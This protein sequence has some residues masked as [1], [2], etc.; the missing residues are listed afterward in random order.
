MFGLLKKI[1]GTAQSR[2]LKRY[3]KL[4]KEVNRQDLFLMNLSDEA[5]RLKT[6]EFKNR[7]SQGE[8]LEK[9]LPE[10]YAVVKNVCRRLTGK[11]IHVSGYDQRWDM[12][13]YDT[14]VLAAIAMHYGNIAEMQTGEGKTLTASMPL[15]LNALT[16]KPVHIVTVN[17]YLA[18]RDSEWVGEIF[19]WLGLTVGALTSDVSPMKRK[20]LYNSDIVYGTAS[21]FG[22]DYLRDNSMAQSAI[23]QVQRGQYFALIDEVDSILIDEARTPLIIS[24]PAPQ[25]ESFFEE[26]NSDIQYLVRLQKDACHQRAI[27]ARRKLEELGLIEESVDFSKKLKEHQKA[28]TEILKSL[29]LVTKGMPHNKV[30]RRIK[31][32]P[33]LRVE[34]DKI[35]TYFYAEPN[36]EEKQKA[37]SELFIIV[38]ERASDFE[39]TDKGI[40]AWTRDETQR[41]QDFVMLD[42]GHEYGLI[43]HNKT[44]DEDEKLEAKMKVREED[45]RRKDRSHSIRQLFRA[46]LLMEKMSTIWCKRGKL[47]SLMKIPEEPNQDAVFQTDC[48]RLLKLKKASRYKVKRKHMLQ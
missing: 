25:S 6:E 22:F 44:L 42:L 20:A 8:T 12:V 5:L 9:L 36:K 31:E 4:V 38:D 18:R 43:D 15:Y 35:D 17:D 40:S 13:P 37:L 33:D 14:Q 2:A 26:L 16:E 1:F 47:S 7:L 34:L 28:V 30:L 21:E 23:E 11:Q 45:S 39:L 10:A 48:I 32:N 41:A 24:G 29:W 27:E 19:R 46:H 3:Q